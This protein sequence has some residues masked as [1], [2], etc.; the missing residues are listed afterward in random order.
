[1]V[2]LSSPFL[3]TWPT[4]RIIFFFKPFPNQ[5]FKKTST[6]R[7][8]IFQKFRAYMWYKWKRA[9]LYLQQFKDTSTPKQHTNCKLYCIKYEKRRVFTDPHS[10]LYM[11]RIYILPLY[12]RIP[13]GKTRISAVN[14]MQCQKYQNHTSKPS[15]IKKT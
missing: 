15:L 7:N 2:C 12:G 3:N 4:W 6:Y 9:Y 14:F 13:V 10:P 5:L 8:G 1:M 11:Y